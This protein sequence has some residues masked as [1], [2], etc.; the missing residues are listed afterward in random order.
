M[1]IFESKVKLLGSSDNYIERDAES[2]N[3]F[4]SE[5]QGLSLEDATAKEEELT[6]IV[7]KRTNPEGFKRTRGSNFKY[8]KYS[9][10]H[11]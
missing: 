5:Y 10:Q 3:T 6:A 11:G 2:H 7:F 8:H 4:T 1:T 9:Y